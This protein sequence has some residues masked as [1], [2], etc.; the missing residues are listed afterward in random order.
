MKFG[1][2]VVPHASMDLFNLASEATVALKS[3]ND[4]MQ[5]RKSVV[6]ISARCK[7]ATFLLPQS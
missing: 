6:V 7:N 4:I 2:T 3:E 1:P 5:G